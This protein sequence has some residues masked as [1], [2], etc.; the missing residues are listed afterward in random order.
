MDD[1]TTLATCHQVEPS[2]YAHLLEEECERFIAVTT[3]ADPKTPI[4]TCPGWTMSDLID[5]VG[6]LHRW[7]EAH[8]RL[9]SPRRISGKELQLGTP[10][11]RG[12][13]P[14]WLRAGL[15]R[16][17]DSCLA[18]DPDSEVWAW[19]A[20][21]HARFWPRRMLFETAIH[22]VDAELALDIPPHVTTSVALDG[23][24]EF[25]D[26]LPHA[27]Y[28]APKVAELR[29]AGERLSLTPNDSD[30]TWTIQ[31]A[32][33]GFHWDHTSHD[34][35]DVSVTA[36]ASELLLFVYGRRDPA[37]STIA[38]RGD[39]SLLARWVESSAI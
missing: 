6:G 39:D 18:G 10:E 30:T 36:S 25:L 15:R 12:A 20:D 14:D 26:N 7:A 23:I 21:K 9:L 11:D 19:G 16:L 5:H 33:D 2:R 31:M 32:E 3:P 38:V 13:Y 22:R 37:S 27:A 8:I 24:D 34:H 4:P 17:V 29:G 1:V 35:S 28:F